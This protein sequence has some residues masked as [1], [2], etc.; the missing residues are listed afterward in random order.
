MYI[1]L[2]PMRAFKLSDNQI[3]LIKYPCY[4]SPKYDGIRAIVFN[5][6]VLSNTLKPIRN[7][8]VQ[9]LLCRYPFLDGELIAGRNFQ[10]TTSTIMSEAGGPLFTYFAFD[11]F[12]RPKDIYLNRLKDIEDIVISQPPDDRVKIVYP[13]RLKTPQDLLDYELDCLQQGYEGCMI[14]SGIG[15]YKYGRSTFNEEYLLKRKPVIDEEA[16]VIGFEE[17]MENLNL[18]EYDERGY[19]KR[20]MHQENKSG[21][22]TLGAFIVPPQKWGDFRIGTGLGLTDAVRKEIWNN[23]QRYLGQILTFKY[24]EFGSKDKPRQPIFLRFRHK[25]DALIEL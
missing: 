13:A 23:Q 9:S 2:K 6:V 22:N 4:G 24:Q 3:D 11:C 15:L 17:Q 25:D 7:L 19:A 16:F 12:Y 14:R 5:N 10:E 8:C 20:S 21:K 18:L 1:G